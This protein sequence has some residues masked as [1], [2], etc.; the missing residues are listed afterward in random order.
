MI[1]LFFVILCLKKYFLKALTF[2]LTKLAMCVRKKFT[3][4]IFSAN[5]PLFFLRLELRKERGKKAISKKKSQSMRKKIFY[6]EKGKSKKKVIKSLSRQHHGI[7]PKWDSRLLQKNT[8]T[9]TEGRW[10]RMSSWRRSWPLHLS[11]R[12]PPSQRPTPT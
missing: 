8:A 7:Q 2:S 12:P 9:R 6:K 10:G 4:S 3:F 1:F 11:P 5:K